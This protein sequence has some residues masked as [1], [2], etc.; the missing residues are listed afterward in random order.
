MHLWGERVAF[1]IQVG[2]TLLIY[3]SDL[4]PSDS[5]IT[6]EIFTFFTLA[7]HRGTLFA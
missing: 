6:G 3:V 4:G 1:G 5:A 2:P 7:D